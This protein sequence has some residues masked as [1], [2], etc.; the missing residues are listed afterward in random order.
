MFAPRGVRRTVADEGV[1]IVSV[2][3]TFAPLLVVSVGWRAPRPA[4][5]RWLDIWAFGTYIVRSSG[6]SPSCIRKTS[7]SDSCEVMLCIVLLER[8]SPESKPADALVW[9]TEG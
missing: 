6:S 8:G 3:L 1:L 5:S 9:E 4:P 7:S 2:T